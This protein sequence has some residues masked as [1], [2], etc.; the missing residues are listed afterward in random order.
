MIWFFRER[1][2]EL[3]VKYQIFV[4]YRR[5][6]GEAL[7]Q[8]M[9]D[10]LRGKG[11][12]VFHDVE[13]LRSGAFN[14]DLLNKIAECEDVLVILPPNGL[15]RCISDPD[16]WVLREISHALK[17]GKNVI[18]IMMRNFEFPAGLPEDIAILPNLNGITCYRKI[19]QSVFV[20]QT[21]QER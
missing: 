7:A 12:V 19:G 17:L 3:P 21:D 1:G 9:A 13:S 16:D 10:R 14:E 2:F 15:D 8:L 4:S 5:D 6:G 18:P 20:Q 11:F